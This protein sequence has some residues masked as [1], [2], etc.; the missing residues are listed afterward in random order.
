MNCRS[1]SCSLPVSARR[2]PP[3]LL[4]PGVWFPSQRPPL[5]DGDIDADDLFAEEAP[6]APIILSL[7]DM[8]K[9]LGLAT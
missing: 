1:S 2:F 3:P 8:K 6:V 5:A 7:A 4:S 9:Q